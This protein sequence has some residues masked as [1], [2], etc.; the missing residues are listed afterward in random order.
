MLGFYVKC[1]IYLFIHTHTHMYSHTYVY[2]SAFLSV[3]VCL[4]VSLLVRHVFPSPL[5]VRNAVI[6]ALVARPILH[7]K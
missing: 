3:C 6:A 1:F 2:T 5:Y 7:S 4:F